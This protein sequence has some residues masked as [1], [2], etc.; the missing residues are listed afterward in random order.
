MVEVKITKKQLKVIDALVEHFQSRA[1]DLDRF[2]NQLYGFLTDSSELMDCVHSLKSRVKDPEHL[3]DKLERKAIAA[4]REGTEFLIAK[5]NLFER[6]NDLV[7]IRILHLH[8]GQFPEI[9][10][11]LLAVL[12]EGRYPLFEDPFVRSWD[13]ETKDFFR[14]CGIAVE[15]SP[16]MYTSVHYVVRASQKAPFTC[17]IQVRTLM[18]EVWGEVD[19]SINYPH[20]TKSVACTEQIKALARLTSGCTRLVDS[21]FSSQEEYKQNRETTE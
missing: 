18:E 16:S 13:D 2:L 10:K 3:R 6:V 14:G 8:T 7:G 1:S 21:I 9:H 4:R 15:D 11:I 20:E 12:D 17:E 5:D 19:H